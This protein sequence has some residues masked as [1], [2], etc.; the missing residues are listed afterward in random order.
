L[1]SETI[2]KQVR[3][4]LATVNGL[5]T[6]YT[7][8]ELTLKPTL[9]ASMTRTLTRCLSLTRTIQQLEE[10][11]PEVD[12][13]EQPYPG[14]PFADKQD[15][16]DGVEMTVEADPLS[17]VLLEEV[18]DSWQGL[19]G[20]I[21]TIREFL[22]SNPGQAQPHM[23]DVM[24]ASVEHSIKFQQELESVERTRAKLAEYE[25]YGGRSKEGAEL[26]K[27]FEKLERSGVLDE[28]AE[29]YGAGSCDSK[30]NIGANDESDEED[31]KHLWGMNPFKKY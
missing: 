24:S 30:A 22:E 7:D 2:A 31:D 19:E 4:L 8:N 27:A 16:A 11:E 17:F 13:N 9:L 1:K 26:H 28:L 3:S 18:L 29:L 12:Y 15:E 14:R 6:E 5:I 10:G 20:L 23:L 21:Q 25:K